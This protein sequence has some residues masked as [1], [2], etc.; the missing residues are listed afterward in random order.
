[1]TDT[2]IGFVDLSTDVYENLEDYLIARSQVVEC[3]MVD[4]MVVNEVAFLDNVDNIKN[5]PFLQQAYN[6]ILQKLIVNNKIYNAKSSLIHY[7]P[8]LHKDIFNVILDAPE[9]IK[10]K[11]RYV[12][13][14]FL[15]KTARYKYATNHDTLYECIIRTKI[16][17]KFVFNDE[18]E[19][20]RKIE[21]YIKSIIELNLLK[22]HRPELVNYYLDEIYPNRHDNNR[23]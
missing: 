17:P 3:D 10:E 16:Y 23:E 12:V 18:T 15:V 5:N 22:K 8:R 19:R 14:N 9:N 7:F 1:M 21:K 6:Y 4:Y 11:F 20:I 13:G 2:D